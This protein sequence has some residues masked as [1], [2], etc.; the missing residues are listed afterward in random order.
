VNEEKSDSNGLKKQQNEIESLTTKSLEANNL[1]AQELHKQLESNLAEWNAVNEKLEMAILEAQDTNSKLI[2]NLSNLNS[3]NQQLEQKSVENICIQNSKPSMQNRQIATDDDIHLDKTELDRLSGENYSY[4]MRI[5]QLVN[6]I[7]SQ[8]H[9]LKIQE[10]L[11]NEQGF[12]NERLESEICA[13]NKECI[14]AKIRA[15]EDLDT[16]LDEVIK[17]EKDLYDQMLTQSCQ[18]VRNEEYHKYTTICEQLK[19]K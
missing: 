6:Q 17:R 12:K 7:E 11:I 8:K 3:A 18:S 5:E 10:S 15:K 13:L 19:Q 4:S 14:E 2:E 16:N 9:Q 1:E